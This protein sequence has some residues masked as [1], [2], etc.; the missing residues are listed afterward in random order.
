M[1]LAIIRF[2]GKERLGKKSFKS[3]NSF[4]TEI[5]K[6]ANLVEWAILMN[7]KTGNIQREAS[8]GTHPHES[9]QFHIYHCGGSSHGS[10]D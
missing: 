5:N 10:D 9:Y 4:E 8:W 1:Y 7:E 3:I 2:K 6:K